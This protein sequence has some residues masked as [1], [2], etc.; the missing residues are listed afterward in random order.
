MS[1]LW[2]FGTLLIFAIG[3]GTVTL[4]AIGVRDA[5]GL[6]FLALAEAAGLGLTAVFLGILALAGV[7]HW[8]RWLVPSGAA[9]TMLWAATRA[10]TWRRPRPQRWSVPAVL[11]FGMM[12]AAC[13]GAVAP[14]TEDDSL[15]YPIPIAQRLAREGRWRFWPDLAHSALP[16]S[17]EVLLAAA[18][19]GGARRYGV[20]SA[21][22][23]VLSGCLIV[24]LARRVGQTG[25]APWVAAIIALGC[26]AVAFLASA[27]KEDLLL[28]AMTLSA[29]VTLNLRPSLASAAASGLFAGLAAG[30]KYSGVPVSIA[31][32]VCVPFCCGRQRPTA[33]V[34][35]ATAVG[36]LSG[37]L[38]YAVN[39]ARFENPVAPFLPFLG[40]PLLAP[41]AVADWVNG[42]GRGRGVLDAVLAPLRIMY[43]PAFGGRGHWIN[44]L[45]YLG[46]VAATQASRR[47]VMLPL[48]AVAGAVYASWFATVQVGRLLLP[49]AGLLSVPA[50]DVIVSL[51]HRVR[52]IRY[53]IAACLAVSA[54][55][56][57]G[58]GLLRID[59]YLAD[60]AT[61]LMRETQHY[62]SIQWMN[63]NLDPGRDRVATWFKSCAYLDI[64]WL[65]LDP[66]YQVEFGPQ[67]LRNPQLLE[68]ALKRQH[69]TYVF[70]PAGAF[71]DIES[72]L[73]L[74][75]VNPHSTLGG[76]RLFRTPPTGAAAI[77]AVR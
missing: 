74:V 11:V 70:G 1:D 62:D 29:A 52:F 2:A 59:R 32:L 55:V 35:V 20:L 14:T 38:W 58:V 19:D 13:L 60:P 31:V 12:G 49:A 47:R 40:T 75:R 16:M 51:W 41:T 24:G 64:P 26:P 5:D 77:Y 4:R 61:F 73:R 17:Q 7:L 18:I 22:E 15:A 66:A 50:A 69:I 27:A 44:P 76:T 36:L 72:E 43:D 48:L 68:A 56:V 53:P 45:A 39:L 33:T 8:D 34:A 37:G 28:L 42:F 54:A 63:A 67:E 21:A 71:R 57:A 9:I 6:D 46:L 3:F 10:R 65:N 30:A 25:W 23:L